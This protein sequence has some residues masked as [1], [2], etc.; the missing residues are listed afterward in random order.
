MTEELEPFEEFESEEAAAAR[1]D[2]LLLSNPRE[3]M[4]A[5]ASFIESRRPNMR[6]LLRRATDTKAIPFYYKPANQE[7]YRLVMDVRAYATRHGVSIDV[8]VDAIVKREKLSAAKTRVLRRTA[9]KGN[10]RVQRLIRDPP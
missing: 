2:S 3:G 7:L 10:P 6:R 9:H 4:A 8:A 1:I 5:F